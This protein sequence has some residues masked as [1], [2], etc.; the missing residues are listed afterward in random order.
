MS[1]APGGYPDPFSN[2]Y[3]RW[4]DGERWTPQTSIP[5]PWAPADPAVPAGPAVPADP[6]VPAGPAA[7]WGAPTPPPAAP[8]YGAPWGGYAGPTAPPLVASF[9]LATYGKRVGARLIDTLILG[10]VLLPVAVAVL[11][12]PM[13]DFFNSL[14]TDGSAP[15]AQVMADF[16]T[17]IVGRVLL[18]SLLALIVQLAYEVPQL[19]LY[20]RTVGKR[21]FGIRVRPLAEDRLPTLKEAMIRWGVSAAGNFVGGGFFTLLDD[22]FPLWD[23]PWQQT[24]HDK[25]A[26][27]VVVPHR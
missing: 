8:G 1:M 25:A 12:T 15:S 7:P 5:Q 22:L 9:P 10:V 13:Q 11:W 4:W 3:L 2:G 24:I 26:K 14:P 27:T 17:R 21:A 23:K 20:G 19:V 6:A 16:E 18:V